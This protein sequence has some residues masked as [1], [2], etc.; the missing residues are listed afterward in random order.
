MSSRADVIAEQYGAAGVQVAVLHNG[1]IGG[2]HEYGVALRAE[3]V[4]VTADTKFR[5][6]SLSKFVTDAVFMAMADDG[7]V[8]EDADVGAYFDVPIRNPG[9]PDVKITPAM[10]MTHTSS[11]VDGAVFLSGRNGNT[12]ISIENIL[13]SESSYASYEPGSH[14]SYSNFGIALLGSICERA[15]GQS[16]EALASKYIFAPLQIDAGYTAS[17]IRDRSLLAELYGVGGYTVEQQL[18]AA[19]SDLIGE[20]YDLV[21]GNLTIS[22]V[23]YAKIIASIVQAANTGTGGVVSGSAARRMLEV[24]FEEQ[25][26]SVGYGQFLQSGIIDDSMLCSHTGSNFGIYSAFAFHP[27]TGDGVVVL[28]S[29]ASGEADNA[30]GIYLICLELIRL[31]WPH[32]E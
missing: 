7:L 11:F 22:A 25:G 3:K 27:E 8:A 13:N 32:A 1:K 5:I 2:T 12:S 23:D 20:T 18:N 16:F 21:Q 17:N 28:T 4:P 19:F 29:G 31:L 15:A 10:L 9:Y 6:A 26:C 24:H 14:Y 30:T